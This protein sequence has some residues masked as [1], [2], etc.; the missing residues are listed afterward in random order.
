MAEIKISKLDKLQEKLDKKIDKEELKKA[1]DIS[2]FDLNA[3]L[4]GIQ[5]TLV[6]GEFALSDPALAQPRIICVYPRA[7]VAHDARAR[8][9]QILRG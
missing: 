3:I 6:G 5:L 8:H 7:Y 4:R 2:H 1:L 9:F